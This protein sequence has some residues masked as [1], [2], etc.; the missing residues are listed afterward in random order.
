MFLLVIWKELLFIILNLACLF[1]FLICIYIL[2]YSNQI[3]F[4]YFNLM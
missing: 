3:P 1:I 4:Y 2:S